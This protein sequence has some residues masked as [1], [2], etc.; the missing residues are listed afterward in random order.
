MAR[1]S[2]AARTRTKSAGKPVES[3]AARAASARGAPSAADLDIRDRLK[4]GP[5]RQAGPPLVGDTLNRAA[6]KALKE[7]VVPKS[8][9]PKNRRG[10]R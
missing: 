2:T 1:K 8:T 6:V 7:E 4:A 5:R 9:D 10:V 3:G